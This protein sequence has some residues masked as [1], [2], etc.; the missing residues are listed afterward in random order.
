MNSLFQ[1]FKPFKNFKFFGVNVSACINQEGEM[2]KKII[3]PIEKLYS[4]ND[5]YFEKIY[6]S[7]ITDYVNPNGISIITKD[8][9]TIDVDDIEKCSILD[10]LLN[11]CSL[12][13]KTRKGYHFYFKKENVLPRIQQKKIADINLKTLFYIPKYY[14]ETTGEE[15]NY[16]I[17]KNDGELVDMPQYAI[18]WCLE[19]IKNE[20]K[21]TKENKIKKERMKRS[22][23]DEGISYDK[24]KNILY[25]ILDGLDVKRFENYGDWFTIACIFVNENY[26]LNIFDEYSKNYKGYD[27]QSNDKIISSLKKDTNGYR[28]ATLYHMVKKDNYELWIKLQS[29]R[30]DFW[31]FMETFNHYDIA[32]VYYQLYPSKYIYS[33]NTWY[34]LNDN[35]IYQKLN[36]FKDTLFNNITTTIQ[37]IIIEQRNLIHPSDDQYSQKN[38][39][40]KKNYNNIGNSTFKKGILEALAGLYYINDIE[41]KLNDN[42]NL[43]AFDDKV[44]DIKSGEYRNIKPDD[45]ISMT[46]GYKSPT[47]DIINKYRQNVEDLLYS[48]FEDKEVMDYWFKTIGLGFFGNKSESLYIHTGTGR[49]GKGVLSNILE[50]CLGSYYQQADS[51]LLT[52]DSKSATNSTL[53]NAKYTRM[54]VLSEP[55]DT[56][57][58]S[59]KL[60]TSLVK[61]ITGGDTITVRDLYKSNISFKP[62]FN[63]ILQCNKKPDIDKLDIAIEQRLKVIHYPFTFLENPSGEF[64]RKIDINLKEKFI[65]NEDFIKCFMAILLEYAYKNKDA[66]MCMPSKVKEQNSLY[67]DENNPVKDFLNDCCEITNNKSDVIGCRELYQKYNECN[68]YKKLDE[69]RFS[70]QMTNLNKIQ[71]KKTKTNNLYVGIKFIGL[72]NDDILI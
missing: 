50:K 53:A 2:K 36:D 52:G 29:K 8:I 34:I 35:N 5:H 11:D 16:S 40:V 45:Y 27:K 4:G 47:Q 72:K 17:Y 22:E 3:S 19:L 56:D 21:Q 51:Q 39:F 54:L 41:T 70:D 38:N 20:T 18:D 71:K 69:K 7:E 28:V 66:N 25:E 23:S 6:S 57:D 60:K 61:S 9:S 33:N 44:Y 37:G 65:N 31:N 24:E 12:I 14:N 30:K 26:D 59:Y 64:E 55:D 1:Q 32:L 15:F 42:V 48:I 49:N 67:F 43:I 13:V 68:I 63:V 10:K 46:V 62:K 58:K